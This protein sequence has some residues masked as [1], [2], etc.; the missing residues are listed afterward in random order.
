MSQACQAARS[1]NL[2]ALRTA[3]SRSLPLDAPDENKWVPLHYA[4]LGC[5]FEVVRYLLSRKVKVNAHTPNRL[6]PLHFAAQVGDLAITSL[7]VEHGSALSPKDSTGQTPLHYSVSSQNGPM[8]KLLLNFSADPN[9][10]DNQGFSPLHLATSLGSQD[11]VEILLQNHAI[12]DLCGPNRTRSPWSPIHIAAQHG[13]TDILIRLLDAVPEQPFAQDKTPTPLH[14]AA[15]H[16]HADVI[17]ILIERGADITALD[18]N[19]EPALFLA[20]RARRIECVRKLVGLRTKL[21]K[22]THQ[23]I[24]LHIAA[25]SGFF[26][27]IEYL[28]ETDREEQ[29]SACDCEGNTAL[30]LALY[31]KRQEAVKVLIEKGADVMARNV[32]RESP[33]TI[34]S[35]ALRTVMNKFIAEH[36]DK[37]QSKPVLPNRTGKMKATK[38]KTVEDVKT[39]RRKEEDDL[40]GFETAIRDDIGKVKEKIHMKFE[41][42]MQCI[43]ELEEDA[44]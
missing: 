14:I 41:E 9:I 19:E 13:Y 44:K 39:K 17:E 2:S 8:V 42:V 26:E 23:Q 33:Y 24:P 20:V 37:W 28:L 27:I 38:K 32:A 40:M 34:A 3:S 7:L 15:S 18:S 35:G 29:L 5:H 16:G 22:N 30:H 43:R 4:V 6:F 11:I 21:F 36:P 10:L 1:G 31:A 25:G 12:P